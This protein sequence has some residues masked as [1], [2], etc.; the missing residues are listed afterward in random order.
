MAKTLKVL[1][2]QKLSEVVNHIKDMTLDLANNLT[3]K[4]SG[5][6]ALDAAMGE[7]LERKKANKAIQRPVILT[8]ANWQGSTAPYSYTIPLAEVTADNLIEVYPNTVLTDEVYNAMANADIEN[9]TQAVGSIT[10]YARG[11]KPTIDLP[12]LIII[13]GD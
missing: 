2:L 4:E 3:T 1:T 7:L 5:K 8:S 9:G 12:I 10:L 13:R 11:V 6:Y